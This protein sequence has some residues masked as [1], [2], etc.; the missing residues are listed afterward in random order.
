MTGIEQRLA[1]LRGGELPRTHNA[2]TIA[3]LATNP[4]CARRAVLD[5]AA[6]DKAKVASRAGYPA[7]FGMSPF[8]QG[9]GVAFERRLKDEPEKELLMLL[10]QALDL[11]I[12]EVGFTDLNDVAG[13]IDLEV[14]HRRTRQLLTAAPDRR[15]TLFDHPLLRFAVGG[16]H[17]FLEPDL[18]AFRHDDTVHVVEIKSFAIIDDQADGAKVAAAAIQ[19]AVYVLALRD[20]LGDRAEVDHQTV[21]IAPRDFSLTPVAA[22]LDVRKQIGVLQRQLS[23]IAAIDDLLEQVPLDVTFSLEADGNGQPR[24]D[25]SELLG[26]IRKVSASYAPQ[27]LASCELCFLCRDEASGTTGALGK[28][29][30]EEAGGLESVQRVLSYAYEKDPYPVPEDLAEA[31]AILRRAATLRRRALGDTP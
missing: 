21:L 29:V 20:L 28:S 24:R 15:S 27:C 1:G 16:R 10:R 17:A 11:D 9:R 13:S 8:A 19:S 5:A 22:T 25:P 6:V 26:D 30:R 31:A 7:S 2:R 23:R 14:R 12:S 4:G 3:A 18:I